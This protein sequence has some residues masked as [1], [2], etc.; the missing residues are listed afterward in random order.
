[1][2]LLHIRS[3][4]A[5][6]VAAALMLAGCGGG[7]S[8]QPDNRGPFTFDATITT[9]DFYDR[10]DD[11][12]YDIF[13]TEVARS[14]RAEVAMSSFDLD[15][16]LFI[17]RRDSNGDYNLIADDDDSGDGP[18]AIVDFDVRRGEVYRVVATSSREQEFGDYRIFFSRELGRPALVASRENGRTATGVDLPAIKAKGAL[19][20]RA[21]Q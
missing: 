10:N 19:E 13:L 17:Y 16:Q 9:R 1:M 3:L 14:G 5:L 21:K 12:Y 2:Q 7:A 18:D 11:R 4:G 8:P 20:K 6:S 15:S